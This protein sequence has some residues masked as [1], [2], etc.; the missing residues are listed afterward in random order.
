MNIYLFTHILP[1][2]HISVKNFL[3]IFFNDKE[4][5]PHYCSM[6]D[7]IMVVPTIITLLKLCIIIG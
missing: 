2:R 1:W 7:K 4:E 5:F 6:N 3:K